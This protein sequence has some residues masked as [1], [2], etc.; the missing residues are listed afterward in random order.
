MED[1]AFIDLIKSGYQRREVR[2]RRVFS[3][4]LKEMEQTIQDM[5]SEEML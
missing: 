2:S 1:L 5:I 4:R 3:S